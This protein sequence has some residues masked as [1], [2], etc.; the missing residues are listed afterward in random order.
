MRA[1]LPF[2][3]IHLPIFLAHRPLF[4]SEALIGLPAYYSPP[5]THPRL[6][7]RHASIPASSFLAHPPSQDSTSLALCSQQKMELLMFYSGCME[8]RIH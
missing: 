1:A 7:P 5:L 3:S 4:P 6:S 8:T 2:P